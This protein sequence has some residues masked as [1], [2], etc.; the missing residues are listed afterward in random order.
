M[1]IDGNYPGEVVALVDVR[2]PWGYFLLREFTNR[3]PEL[4]K[5]TVRATMNESLGQNV[6][7]LTSFCSSV[8]PASA[9]S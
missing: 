7:R 3:I 4:R 8:R 1:Q 5:D 2:C 9:A 6:V